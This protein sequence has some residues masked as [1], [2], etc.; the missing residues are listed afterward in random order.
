MT[1]AEVVGK[2][3]PRLRGG[4][5]WGLDRTRRILSALGD[6]HL[7]FRSLHV[8]G[9]NGKGSVSALLASV[10]HESGRRVGLY[11]SPHLCTFRERIQ[12]GGEPVGEADVVAAAE[13]IWPLLIEEDA[14][15][16][17]ATTALAF[18]LFAEAGVEVAVVEVG[19]GGR[20]DS[21]NVIVPELAVITNVARDHT[22]HLGDSLEAIAGEKAGI[23]KPGVPI[24]T[25]ESDP[26]VL[27]V[28]RSR[29]EEL[30]APLHRF[31]PDLVQGA[32]VTPDGTELHLR[33]G[34]WGELELRT[35]LIG[36]HQAGNVGLAVGALELLSPELRPDR[37]EV[38][39][40]VA[41]VRWPGR[42]QRERVA[43]DDW[44]FDVAHNPAAIEVL[45]DTLAELPVASPLAAL[46][47][48]MG[49]KDWRGMMQ[50]L[51]ESVDHLVLTR[52]L[53]APPGRSW[54]PV[55]GLAEVPAGRGEVVEDFEEALR[56]VG[57]R[58]AGG[59]VLV[60]GSFHTVGDALTLLGLAPF[61][62]D[63]ALP[64][65]AAGI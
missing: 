47:G 27:E 37:A 48:I 18:L 1:Y 26:I 58:G 34:E 39:R 56:V 41:G 14:S 43:G 3:F 60:T 40:G 9:T 65:E 49:D 12:I 19:L 44:I 30:G 16:F 54:D 57:R 17:E 23:I 29:A 7:S 20:L 61:G 21:T 13:R 33:T 8:G 10:L 38:V 28:L 45:L 5:H 50:R 36:E 24:L 42:F 64:A 2:L 52:P 31:T 25:G 6:P 15:F 59:T 51:S 22:D 32:R 46:V 62:S 53:S 63:P 11:T 55:A 35:S 4:I